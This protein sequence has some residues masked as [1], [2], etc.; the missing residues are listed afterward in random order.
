MLVGVKLGWNKC[1]AYLEAVRRIVE[2]HNQSHK[3]AGGGVDYAAARYGGQEF[4]LA[5]N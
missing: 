3:A 4:A 1:D 2:K 5:S